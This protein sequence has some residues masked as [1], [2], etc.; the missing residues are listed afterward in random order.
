MNKAEEY[1]DMKE[2]LKGVDD[3]WLLYLKN[4]CLEEVKRRAEDE[5]K[6]K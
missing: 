5:L 4:C 6:K 2:L 1:S 3:K